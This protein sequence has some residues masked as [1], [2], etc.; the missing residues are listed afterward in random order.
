VWEEL[1]NTKSMFSDGWPTYD[2]DKLVDE[3]IT[4][5]IQI[6]GKMRATIIISPNASK[7]EARSIALD[8]EKI[9]SYIKGKDLKEI[10]YVPGRIMNIVVK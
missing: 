6:N 7:D 2:K 5:A 9:N 4:L 1:G 10:I 8:D 3:T